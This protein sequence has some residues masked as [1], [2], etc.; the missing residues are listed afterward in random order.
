[1]ETEDEKICHML[2]SMGSEAVPIYNHYIF[3]DK[4]AKRKLKNAIELFDKYFEPVENVIFERSIFEMKQEPGESI[5]S[6]I[7]KLQ[8][9]SQNCEY[10]TMRAETR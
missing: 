1:M 3:D 10:G 6:I 5:H 9:Q 7:V 8:T 4:Q 2:V